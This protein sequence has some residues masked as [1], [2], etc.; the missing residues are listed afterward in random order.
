MQME[1]NL[2]KS[3][4]LAVS[5]KKLEKCQYLPI[6][7]LDKCMISRNL[8]EYI[9]RHYANNKSSLLLKGARQVGKTYAICK[10]AE[11]F[12]VSIARNRENWI[13]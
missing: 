8:D 3:G 10:Y 9:E 2:S 7:A 11:S 12:I 13:S 4:V 5:L 1:N 6:F